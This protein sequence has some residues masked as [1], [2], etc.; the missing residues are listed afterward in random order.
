[1]S[2]LALSTCSQIPG[3]G[4]GV[5]EVVGHSQGLDSN[6]LVGTQETLSVTCVLQISE[7]PG[8]TEGSSPHQSDLG[9][10]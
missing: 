6:K 10:W 3:M 1:M 9:D 2:A 5:A 7:K 8:V 4:Q